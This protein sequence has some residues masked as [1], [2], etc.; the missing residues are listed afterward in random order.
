MNKQFHAAKNILEYWSIGVPRPVYGRYC[1]SRTAR[2]L[3]Y[4]M[5]NSGAS[6]YECIRRTYIQLTI[7]QTFV[8]VRLWNS[9]S[10]VFLV[11]LLFFLVFYTEYVYVVSINSVLFLSSK[12][13][14]RTR[15]ASAMLHSQQ[16]VFVLTVLSISV[17]GMHVRTTV[18]I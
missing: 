5:R 17:S 15:N 4:Q 6:T 8:C 18:D 3:K 7:L 11:H 13:T 12:S 2:S 10:S 1:C 9:D 14:V 16:R